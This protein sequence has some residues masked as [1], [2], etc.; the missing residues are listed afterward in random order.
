MSAGVF[1]KRSCR[2]GEGPLW[3]PERKQLF[4]FDILDKKFLS[5]QGDNQLEWAF[6][7]HVSAAGWVSKDELLIASESQLFLFHLKTGA[8]VKHRTRSLVPMMGVRILGAVSGLARWAKRPKR[9]R[10]RF[11]VIIAVGWN[12]SIPTSRY[13]IRFVFPQIENLLI[14]QIH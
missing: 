10:V 11:I 14:S 7:E 13:Q 4:W 1:D 2:L 6:D 5:R 9:M 8:R 3:H 12:C